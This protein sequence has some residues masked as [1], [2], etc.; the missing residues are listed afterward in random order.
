[1]RHVSSREESVNSSNAFLPLKGRLQDCNRL[2]FYF[3]H[4]KSEPRDYGKIG[5][6]LCTQINSWIGHFVHHV[7][8]R[9]PES[10]LSTCLVTMQAARKEE[11]VVCPGITVPLVMP[12][13]HSQSDFWHWSD[14]LVFQHLLLCTQP[15]FFSLFSPFEHWYKTWVQPKYMHFVSNPSF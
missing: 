14:G 4:A 8:V 9:R 1:M 2:Q 5:I 7:Y 15:P 10:T 12:T 11:Q 6:Y 3:P 13:W